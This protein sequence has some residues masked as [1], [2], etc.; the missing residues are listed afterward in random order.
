MYSDVEARLGEVLLSNYSRRG[1]PI[2]SNAAPVVVEFDMKLH[3]IEKLVSVSS[4][5]GLP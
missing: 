1:R 4:S 3:K 5:I 2:E